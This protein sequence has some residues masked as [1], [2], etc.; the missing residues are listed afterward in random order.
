M[1]PFP[2]SSAPRD[3]TE[4]L[5]IE[6]RNGNWSYIE[7]GCWGWI[8]TSDWDGKQIYGWT[9]DGG[10]IEDPTHWLPPLTKPSQELSQEDREE[11]AWEEAQM[12]ESGADRCPPRE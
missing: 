2:I 6:F 11:R 1:I 7:H 8:E 4:I 12:Q 9:T 3:G 5:L 10:Y